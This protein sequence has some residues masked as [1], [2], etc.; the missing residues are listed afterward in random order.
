MGQI[1]PGMRHVVH[2]VV[3][4]LKT[5]RDADRLKAAVAK[6]AKKFAGKLSHTRK[7]K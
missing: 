7:K 1:R 5:K 4:G 3:T 6:L 2:I